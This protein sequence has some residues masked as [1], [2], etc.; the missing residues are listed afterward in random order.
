MIGIFRMSEKDFCHFSSTGAWVRMIVVSVVH[1][2]EHKYAKG[3][4][5]FGSI[6][7]DVADSHMWMCDV[8]C[9]MLLE[10]T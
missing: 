7:C 2:I 1:K 4:K 9:V 10:F 3:I 6:S 8:R 5:R